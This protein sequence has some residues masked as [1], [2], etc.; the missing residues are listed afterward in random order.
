MSSFPPQKGWRFQFRNG[1]R[2]LRYPGDR[3]FLCLTVRQSLVSA[4]AREDPGPSG[5]HGFRDTKRLVFLFSFA[6]TLFYFVLQSCWCHLRGLSLL[7][8]HHENASPFSR[9]TF[10]IRG[11]P[12]SVPQISPLFLFTPRSLCLRCILNENLQCPA[13]NPK[14]QTHA[15]R[16]V[17]L[18]RL[19]WD[20]QCPLGR[21]FLRSLIVSLK[22]CHLP[23]FDCP[24]R[25]SSQG[26]VVS[27]N[28]S[29][30]TDAAF[31]TCV[32]L[33]FLLV[34]STSES[35]FP[36]SLNE[37]HVFLYFV[38]PFCVRPFFFQSLQGQRREAPD[39]GHAFFCPP[40]FPG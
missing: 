5:R 16:G 24:Q 2:F 10:M 38:S 35:H 1:P 31:L 40:T 25:G 4:V 27:G 11:G 20:G 19:R 8:D 14:K 34:T 6:F 39:S 9:R 13:P 37:Y 22:V 33:F 7:R 29:A 3:D 21:G 18:S 30:T 28:R 17:P 23:S 12:Y 15:A 36:S 26:R 32:D